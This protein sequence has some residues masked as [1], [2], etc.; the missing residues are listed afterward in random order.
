LEFISYNSE[1]EPF[2]FS[3]FPNVEEDEEGSV[4]RTVEKP[5]VKKATRKAK[6]AGRK[7]VAK[8]KPKTTLKKTTGN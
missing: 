4:A 8:K 1:L 7:K 5:A 6:P 3:D 2:P